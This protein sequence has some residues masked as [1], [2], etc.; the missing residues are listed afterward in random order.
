MKYWMKAVYLIV[1]NPEVE[2]L[3]KIDSAFLSALHVYKA[4]DRHLV[5]DV[6]RSKAGISLQEFIN[7]DGTMD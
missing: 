5:V 2:Q 3:M 1:S 7:N 6:A 4:A